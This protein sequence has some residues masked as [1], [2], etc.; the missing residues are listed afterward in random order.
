MSQHALANESATILLVEDS[1]IN[2]MFARKSFDAV[3]IPHKVHVAVNGDEAMA[4][5]RAVGA[6]AGRPQ[7]DLVLLDLN[8]PKMDGHEVLQAMKNDVELRSI[9]VIIFTTSEAE[10]DIRRAYHEHANAYVI[11][12]SCFDEWEQLIQSIAHFW[13]KLAKRPP[14]V[15]RVCRDQCL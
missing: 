15:R 2:V 14:P 7:P 9:P 13:L 11:K 5:L 8:M 4:F 1:T 3:T 12:P 10:T 6:Y